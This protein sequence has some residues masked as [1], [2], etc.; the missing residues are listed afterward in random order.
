MQESDL[1]EMA[2]TE[3][4]LFTILGPFGSHQFSIILQ[5]DMYL[6]R[7]SPFLDLISTVQK[8]VKGMYS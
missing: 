6:F 4:S 5:K 3:S 7:E 2:E 8:K 1:S